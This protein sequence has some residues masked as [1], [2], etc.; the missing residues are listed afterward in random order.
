MH[1]SVGQYTGIIRSV[2]YLLSTGINLKSDCKGTI[3][4]CVGKACT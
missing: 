3:N 1:V 4:L 2:L